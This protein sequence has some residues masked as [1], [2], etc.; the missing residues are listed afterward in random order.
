[1]LSTIAL[2]HL[3]LAITT[4]PSLGCFSRVHKIIRASRWGLL[5][6]LFARA[7]PHC[8]CQQH[9]ILNEQSAYHHAIGSAGVQI[10]EAAAAQL[11]C[12]CGADTADVRAALGPEEPGRR[13]AEVP[14]SDGQVRLRRGPVSDCPSTGI[15]LALQ[16][17]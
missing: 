12:C 3:H 8:A 1:M 15:A 7:I 17:D 14:L 4:C 13:G 10:R 11:L 6:S 5:I 9:E 2:V 16:P